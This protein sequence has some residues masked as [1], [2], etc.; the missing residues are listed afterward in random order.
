MRSKS[1]LAGATAV[2]G[3]LALG[4]PVVGA[5]ASTAATSSAAAKTTCTYKIN[6]Q[7]PTKLSGF[8]FGYVNC[9]EPFGN[10]VQSATYTA[11]LNTKTGA[12]TTKGSYRNWFDTGTLYGTYSLRGQYT[13]ATRATFKGTFTIT[14]GTGAFKAAKKATGTL[15][16]STTN[17]D[18]TSTCTSVLK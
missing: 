6:N 13:S 2:V 7:T 9:P 10:G 16:C 8:S 12:A 15:T 1:L 4:V 14:G 17:A 18:A 5:A 11:T 3:S